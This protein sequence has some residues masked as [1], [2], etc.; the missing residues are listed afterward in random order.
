MLK[1]YCGNDLVKVRETAFAVVDKLA[2]GDVRVI[3]IDA[4]TYVE[5]VLSDAAGAASLFGE[6]ELYVLDTP[7]GHKDFE[8]A[9]FASLEALGE[10]PNQFIVIEGTLL[11][12]PKKKYQKYAESLE[13]FKGERAE[14]FN[15]FSMADALA[16]KD[17]KT[18]W[19]LLQE[20]KLDGLSDEEII[21]TLWWQLKSLR[22]AAV[23]SS[24]SEAGMKDF[25]YNKA[26]RSLSNFK[27]GELETTSRNLLSVYHDGHAGVRDIDLALERFVLTL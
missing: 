6:T 5:G 25:P 14:R 19:L 4:D 9:V 1:V 26:K 2:K 16:R 24:A 23:T 22:L 7:S 12:A 8:A 27:D 17:K 18:L 10:S 15:V 20:A 13:E 21:G 11:A 3:T